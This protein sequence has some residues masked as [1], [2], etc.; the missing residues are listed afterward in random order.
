VCRFGG[1]EAL[2]HLADVHRGAGRKLVPPLGRDRDLA[3]PGP[4]DQSLHHR[5]DVT[6]EWRGNGLVA[7]QLGARDVHLDELGVGVPLGCI[8]VSEQPV[9][10]RTDEQHDVGPA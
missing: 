1:L 10:A 5:T 4:L 9:Q 2:G 3:G 8:A 7:V 6:D